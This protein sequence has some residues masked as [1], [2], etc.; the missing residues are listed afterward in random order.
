[1]TTVALVPLR[2]G[3][4]SIPNKNIK[5]IGG[6]PLCAWVLKAAAQ[7]KLVDSV[8]VSTDSAK[9]SEVVLNLELDIKIIDRPTKYSTDKAS[10]ESVMMHF[11]E[12]VNFDKLITIQ[13]TSPLLTSSCIDKALAQFT[14]NNADSMLSGVR[15]KRFFW[16]DEGIPIN[17]NYLKRPRRQDFKG[18][19]ME[20]GAFYITKLEILKKYKCRLGG[21]ID[22][23]EMSQENAIEID[24]EE[25]WELVSNLIEQKR[26]WK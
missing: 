14:K 5:V 22:L 15:A 9:I 21:K 11:L 8:Y 3:S 20:N 19:F 2:G 25:D 17:Y 24:E 4:K 13:A 26:K 7:S 12:Q 10:T 23:F 6:K 16:N 18:T 1:M